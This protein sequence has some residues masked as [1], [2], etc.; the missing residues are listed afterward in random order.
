MTM[1]VLANRMVIFF[2]FNVTSIMCFSYIT[3]SIFYGVLK[4]K[5]EPQNKI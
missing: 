5:D 3:H 4:E 1:I 2:I